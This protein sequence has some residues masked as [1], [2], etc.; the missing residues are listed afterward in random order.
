MM[1]VRDYIKLLLKKKKWSRFKLCQELNKVEAKISDARTV[2]QNVTNYLN[3]YFEFS[4]YTLI[5]YEAVFNLPVGTLISMVE[6]PLSKS[7]RDELNKLIK[8]IR[9][10]EYGNYF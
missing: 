5:K 10:D 8:K 1:T 2:P 7:A 6:Q 4:V 3:G 9:G